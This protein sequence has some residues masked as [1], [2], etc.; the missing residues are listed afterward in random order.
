MGPRVRP[1]PTVATATTQL[2]AY[3]RALRAANLVGK[4]GP[5]LAPVLHVSDAQLAALFAPKQLL[6]LVVRP[7]QR[8]VPR[9]A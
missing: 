4:N 6:D 7:L 8:S 3:V 1:A 2:D 9:C 5:V